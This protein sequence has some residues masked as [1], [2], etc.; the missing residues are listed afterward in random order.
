MEDKPK[1]LVIHYD[2]TNSFN[3]ILAILVSGRLM[4]EDICDIN[5]YIPVPRNMSRKLFSSLSE[6]ISELHENDEIELLEVE[7]AMFYVSIV[8]TKVFFLNKSF[9]EIR[10]ILPML[11]TKTDREYKHLI[12]SFLKFSDKMLWFI[13]HQFEGRE[14]FGEALHLLG[15]WTLRKRFKIQN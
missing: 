12:R 6:K 9:D 3:S 1:H 11:G 14:I 2:V 8:L 7:V 5:E 10:Q 15:N 4:F 13:A